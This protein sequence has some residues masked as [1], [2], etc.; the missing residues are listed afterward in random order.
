V[1]TE[2]F[3]VQPQGRTRILDRASGQITELDVA[4]CVRWHPDAVRIGEFSSTALFDPARLDY[5]AVAPANLSGLAWSDDLGMSAAAPC[6]VT[7]GFAGRQ[8]G[9]LD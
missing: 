5:A 8:Q 6:W 7:A 2:S 3:C 9:S 4:A 1:W